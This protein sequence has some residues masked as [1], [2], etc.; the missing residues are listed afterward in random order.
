[1]PYKARQ[2][3][4]ARHRKRSAQLHNKN[5]R[6][7]KQSKSKAKQSAAICTCTPWQVAS[8]KW[9]TQHA[10][11][12]PHTIKAT[13]TFFLR[14]VPVT[15]FPR[16]VQPIPFFSLSLSPPT[17]SSRHQEIAQHARMLPMLMFRRSLSCLLR[18][19]AQPMQH[20]HIAVPERVIVHL[21]PILL[22]QRRRYLSPA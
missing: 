10:T 4:Q 21:Y 3:A 16:T 8:G 14:L 1:V 17:L 20:L 5:K 7:K 6:G 13:T 9:Q 12:Q 15:H 22:R 2:Q 11:V 19:H 18:C